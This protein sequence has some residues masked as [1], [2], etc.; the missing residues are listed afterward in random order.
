M[1]PDRPAQDAPQTTRT[2]SLRFK[3]SNSQ[4]VS[5]PDSIGRSSIPETPVLEPRRRGVLDAPDPP[6]PRL[7]RGSRTQGH[8]VALAKAASRGMTAEGVRAHS[9]GTKCPSDASLARPRNQRGRR[10]CRVPLHPQPR[11]QEMRK[12]THTS[13]QQ[14]QPNTLRHPLRSGFRLITRSPRCP[15]FDSH[16]RRRIIFRQ[17]DPSVGGS[18]PHA[19]AVR[20]GPRSS[21]AS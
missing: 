18:G 11:V 14:V 19:F 8:A 21:L 3:M 20:L 9:R 13:S 7:R 12:A 10:E 16:R 4:S 1:P 6:T 2:Q 17:L 5:S 15:G